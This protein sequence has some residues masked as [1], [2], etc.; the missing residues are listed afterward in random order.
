M[1]ELVYGPEVAMARRDKWDARFMAIAAQVAT[2][3]KDRSTQVG[4]VIVSLDRDILATGYNGFPRRVNDDI[5]TRHERPAKYKFTEHA[6]RNAVY[7][8]AKRGTALVGATMY[9]PWF[10][11]CDCA[12]AIVQ[13]GIS[14]LVAF[15]P[16]FADE[17]WGADHRTAVE[18]LA[19]SRVIITYLARPSTDT[20]EP[21][22]V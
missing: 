2:W 21:N 8:A 9:V 11:C 5:D 12:R 16:D 6:E 19:E 7:A 15:E 14:R 13:A 20:M 4:C 1:S 18:I 22:R 17:R 10:P 3:S